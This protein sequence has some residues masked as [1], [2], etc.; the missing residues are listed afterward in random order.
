MSAV[1]AKHKY[2]PFTTRDGSKACAECDGNEHAEQ[3]QPIQEMHV[4]EAT[5]I[6][7]NDPPVGR[8]DVSPCLPSWVKTMC[9][10]FQRGEG[11]ALSPGAVSALAH[12]LIGARVRAER[13]VRERDEAKQVAKEC[14]FAVHVGWVNEDDLEKLPRPPSFEE[15]NSL[16]SA[17]RIRD[18]VRMFPCVRIGGVVHLL[19]YDEDHENNWADHYFRKLTQ[20]Q[21]ANLLPQDFEF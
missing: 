16:F 14:A 18:G 2:R 1:I 12:T 20:L 10:A 3:H 7:K 15:Y 5:T 6:M 17:S 11:Y 9:D 13:L 19:T 4:V 21:A 8:G